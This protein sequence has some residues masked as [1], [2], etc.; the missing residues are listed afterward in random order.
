MEK[1][2]ENILKY[3]AKKDNISIKNAILKLDQC[4][5]TASINLNIINIVWNK[6]VEII[7]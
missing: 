4:M 1:S 7:S 5:K 6:P 3:V 2:L